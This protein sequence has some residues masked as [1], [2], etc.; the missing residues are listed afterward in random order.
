[1]LVLFIST[2]KP[3]FHR[4][5]R[6]Y[7]IIYR[8][9]PAGLLRAIKQVQG[10][11]VTYENHTALSIRMLATLR[12]KFFQQARYQK[13]VLQE[14][15]FKLW[16]NG[17]MH[18]HSSILRQGNG[19][20]LLIDGKESFV[21]GPIQ[22]SAACLM[23]DEPAEFRRIFSEQHGA[24]HDLK[25]NPRTHQYHKTDP[26]GKINRYRYEQGLLQ[27]A[28]LDAGLLSFELQLKK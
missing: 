28:E 7:D 17:S 23:L 6:H 20:R 14:A 18:R 16:V 11:E 3:E 9:E 5:E 26:Q 1:M 24:F 15:E 19:Y 12:L 27:W 21:D 10:E 22:Y 8:N 2:F 25:M 4:Q 13:G